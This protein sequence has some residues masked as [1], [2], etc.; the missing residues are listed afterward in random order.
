MSK[1]TILG[2]YL[3]ALL[4][5]DSNWT[6]KNLHRISGSNHNE[7]LYLA[8]WDSFLYHHRFRPP[9]TEMKRYYTEHIMKLKSER[10]D[11]ELLINQMFVNHITIAYILDHK[12]GNELFNIMIKN[13]HTAFIRHLIQFIGREI[14]GEYRRTRNI[15]L[16][17][18]KIRQLWEDSKFK[19]YIEFGW[20]F[21]NTP[22]LVKGTAFYVYNILFKIRMEN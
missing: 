1:T 15:G 16:N 10:N 4:Y 5:L 2:T 11:D 14:L 13:I 9:R 8:V 3:P 7:K 18:H 22:L 20:W 12:L 21:I 6:K 19:A 17:L